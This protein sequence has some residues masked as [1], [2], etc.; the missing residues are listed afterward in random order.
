MV[1]KNMRI[2]I[3]ILLS[4]LIPEA[5]INATLIPLYPFMVRSLLPNETEIGYYAG[6]LG[7]LFYF[8]SLIM[9]VV[10]GAASDRVGRK[11]ILIAGIIVCGIAT[12]GLGLTKSYSVTL[13]CRFLAGVFGSNPIVAKGMIGHMA[14]DQPSRA[15]AYS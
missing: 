6:I 2:Q 13:G 12:L 7:S 9:N 10:W 14:R 11:P 4:G 15:W 8:P 5:L 1:E 3:F